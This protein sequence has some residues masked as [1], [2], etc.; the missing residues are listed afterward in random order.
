MKVCKISQKIFIEDMETAQIIDVIIIK[1][2]ILN[3]LFYLFDAGADR[4]S[5]IGWI[6]ALKG[7]KNDGTVVV[8]FEIT[9]HHCHFV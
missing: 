8:V 6:G 9:L 5:T 2:Q 7:I 1:M 4:I 3:I